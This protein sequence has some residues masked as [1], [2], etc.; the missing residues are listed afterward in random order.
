MRFRTIEH[1]DGT[2]DYCDGIMEEFDGT[3]NNCGKG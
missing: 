2:F 3:L 1:S